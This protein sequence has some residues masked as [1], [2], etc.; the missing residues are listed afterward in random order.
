MSIE[1]IPAVKDAVITDSYV[2]GPVPNK[3]IGPDRG[4]RD[5]AV[6]F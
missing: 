6:F 1:D 3:A 5:P 4:S 2:I